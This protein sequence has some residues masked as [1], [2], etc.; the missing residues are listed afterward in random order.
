MDEQTIK[1]AARLSAAARAKKMAPHICLRCDKPVRKPYH[2]HV[3]CAKLEDAER[4]ARIEAI[5]SKPLTLE[6]WCRMG[7]MT[8][9]EGRESYA[10]W[11]ETHA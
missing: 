4:R 11:K 7:G 10:N 3:G 8:L 9:D 6:V 1:D 2:L 5:P